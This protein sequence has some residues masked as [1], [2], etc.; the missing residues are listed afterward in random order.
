[1][2]DDST[3]SLPFC[4]GRVFARHAGKICGGAGMAAAMLQMANRS[5]MSGAPVVDRMTLSG[6]L[7]LPYAGYLVAD[8]R[9]KPGF[10]GVV[11]ST[12]LPVA[13][14]LSMIFERSAKPVRVA[15]EKGLV[16]TF[17]RAPLLSTAAAAVATKGLLLAYA[18]MNRE[19]L[20]IP[21]VLLGTLENIATGMMDNSVRRFFGVGI[22][23]NPQVLSKDSIKL[24]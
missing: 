17:K 5:Y 2:R 6:A 12:V 16:A 22:K 21:A 9:G 7:G 1:M 13:M 3:P 14:C 8:A 20:F 23:T 15:P 11:A 4:L 18:V 10:E 19:T 24:R